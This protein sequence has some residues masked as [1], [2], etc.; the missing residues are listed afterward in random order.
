MKLFQ[1]FSKHYRSKFSW[2]QWEGQ[3]NVVNNLTSFRFSFKSCSFYFTS[4]HSS[5]NRPVHSWPVFPHEVDQCASLVQNRRRTTL[6]P[7]RNISV[8]ELAPLLSGSNKDLWTVAHL[9]ANCQFMTFTCLEFNLWKPCWSAEIES[10]DDD[11]SLEEPK[12]RPLS[13]PT[14]K[15]PCSLC[16]YKETKNFIYDDRFNV[17]LFLW[18]SVLQLTN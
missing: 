17:L 4:P 7:A 15:V 14:L 3:T 8:D 9:G 11:C 13:V 1:S 5:T 12:K 18:K 10:G 16:K 2:N 6:I